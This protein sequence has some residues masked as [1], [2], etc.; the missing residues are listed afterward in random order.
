MTMTINL[1]NVLLIR[2]TFAGHHESVEHVQNFRVPSANIFL[3]WLC[4]L[5]MCSYLLCRTAYVLYSSHSSSS[6]STLLISLRHTG[7]H[8]GTHAILI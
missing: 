5:T 8:R 2:V 6:N 1:N 3:S 7:M 4:A